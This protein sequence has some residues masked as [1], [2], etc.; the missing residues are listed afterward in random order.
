MSAG[1][2]H[3][4]DHVLY[5]CGF[6]TSHCEWKHMVR[7]QEACFVSCELLVC[8]NACIEWFTEPLQTEPAQLLSLSVYAWSQRYYFCC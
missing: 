5:V 2:G 7:Q 6:H 8:T 1:Y 4:K 3:E